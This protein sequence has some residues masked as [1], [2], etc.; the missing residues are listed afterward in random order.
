MYRLH[1][2]YVFSQVSLLEGGFRDNVAMPRLVLFVSI[3]LF[4]AYF[5]IFARLE[6]INDLSK[7]IKG[8]KGE[9]L[10]SIS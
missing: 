9:V 3:V 10:K 6:K 8:D 4:I 2:L 1:T 7:V 5:F